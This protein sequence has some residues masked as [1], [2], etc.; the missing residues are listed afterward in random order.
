MPR[1]ELDWKVFWFGVGFVLGAVL[2]PGCADVPNPICEPPAVDAAEASIVG[3]EPVEDRRA[4]V[5]VAGPNG[6]CSGTAVGP[7]VVLTAAHCPD[8]DRVCLDGPDGELCSPVAHIE[9]H[10]AWESRGVD[11]MLV[12]TTDV[13]RPPYAAIGTT[14]S[15]CT[16]TLAMGFGQGSEPLAQREVSAIHYDEGRDYVITTTGACYGDS[17]SGLYALGTGRLEIIGVSSFLTDENCEQALNG[18]VSL[19]GQHS[20]WVR[21]RL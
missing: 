15:E 13:L 12:W 18:W 16:G 8:P 5:A 11:L 14:L 17:G 10:W 4:V 20:D 3:G 21:A 6:Y 19:L 9:R 2:F 7:E 1:E